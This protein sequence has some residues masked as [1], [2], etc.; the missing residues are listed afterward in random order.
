MARRKTTARR[1]KK[2][3][4]GKGVMKGKIHTEEKSNAIRVEGKN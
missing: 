1:G 4:G 3:Q 2:L